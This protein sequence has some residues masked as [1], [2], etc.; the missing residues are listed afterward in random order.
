MFYYFDRI[1]DILKSKNIKYYHLGGLDK[2]IPGVYKFKGT[3]EFQ[4]VVEFEYSNLILLRV[5][6][7]CFSVILYSRELRS[8]FPFISKL[9]I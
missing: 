9:N 8:I 3:K 5:F 1:V 6:V 4:Y 2:K 7:V